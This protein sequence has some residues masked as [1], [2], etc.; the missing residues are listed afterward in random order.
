MGPH[1]EEIASVF[2]RSGGLADDGDIGG[3]PLTLLVGGGGADDD[4]GGHLM[5]G[6]LMDGLHDAH[7]GAVHGAALPMDE[8]DLMKGLL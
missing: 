1:D 6:Q 3:T 4:L 5:G 7:N 8:E 2:G